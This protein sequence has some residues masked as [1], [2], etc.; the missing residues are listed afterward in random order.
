[1]VQ[2]FIGQNTLTANLGDVNVESDCEGDIEGLGEETQK[3]KEESEELVRAVFV[4]GS[5]SAYVAFHRAFF[6]RRM[7][8]FLG[9]NRFSS[10]A[11][12]TRSCSLPSNPKASTLA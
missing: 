8:Y 3:A 12:R 5:F 4:I 7:K 11:A 9:G 10:I 2:Y 1:M 6:L